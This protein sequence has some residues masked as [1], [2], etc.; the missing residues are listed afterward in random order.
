MCRALSDIAANIDF[1]LT[2][3]LAYRKNWKMFSNF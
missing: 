2:K 3:L 1:F